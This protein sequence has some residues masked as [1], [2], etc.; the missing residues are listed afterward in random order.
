MDLFDRLADS[1][2]NP[3]PEMGS[4]L[5]RAEIDATIAS[6][7]GVPSLDQLRAALGREPIV[8]G[9]RL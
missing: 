1:Q 2:L 3:L 7:L 4:D 8:S 5:V 9:A 6:V